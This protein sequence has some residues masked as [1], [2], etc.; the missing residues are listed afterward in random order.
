MVSKENFEVSVVSVV[1]DGGVDFVVLGTGVG[2]VLYFVE[3][4]I[5]KVFDYLYF[6]YIP[7]LLHNAFNEGLVHLGQTADKQLPNE[8]VFVDF[9]A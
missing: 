4:N 9:F 5:G 1:V 3:L 7:I 2:C 6:L 8:D